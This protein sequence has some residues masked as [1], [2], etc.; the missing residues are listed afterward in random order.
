MSA[1]HARKGY[2]EFD[3]GQERDERGRFSG[4]GSVEPGDPRKLKPA[5]EAGYLYH[6]TN[7]LNFAD[8]R[9]DGELRV[10]GPSYGTD[11]DE[12]PDGGTEDRSYWNAKPSVVES[13]Y[14]EEG[15]PVL[16]RARESAVAFQRERYTSDSYTRDVVPAS[17]LEYLGSDGSWHA[18]KVSKGYPEFDPD[19]PRD[20]GGRF[21][22]ASG[23][24]RDA[25]ITEEAM[26]RRFP[27]ARIVAEQQG[28]GRLNVRITNSEVELN[29]VV[30][31][32]DNAYLG[33]IGVYGESEEY[34]NFAREGLGIVLDAARANNAPAIDLYAVQVGAYVWPKIGFELRSNL[35]A[36]LSNGDF[37]RRLERA[38]SVLPDT[39]WQAVRDVMDVR[40]VTLPH[41]L[42]NLGYELSH[43]DYA[44]ISGFP[45]VGKPM[46]GKALLHRMSGNYTL[47][48]AKF[49][50]LE[51]Y[52]QV[53]KG[54]PEFD[55][56]QPRNEDGTWGSTGRMGSW[57]TKE[58]VEARF[59]GAAVDYEP[60]PHQKGSFTVT[61]RNQDEAH[62]LHLRVSYYPGSGSGEGQ[63][64][65]GLITTADTRVG[66]ETA[67][68]A[69]AF[70]L[71]MAEESGARSIFLSAGL[72]SGGYVWP[73]IGF[74]SY[75]AWDSQEDYVKRLD[76]AKAAGLS[77][78]LY[79]K[80]M[81]VVNNTEPMREMPSA[82]AQ[83]DDPVPLDVFE[84]AV[85]FIRTAAGVKPTLGK[86]ILLAQGGSF[87]LPREKYSLL[88]DW[89]SRPFSK[90]MR[91]GYPEFDPNQP[92]EEDGQWGSGG[93]TRAAAGGK[94]TFDLR[95]ERTEQQTRRLQEMLPARFSVMVSRDSSTRERVID[96][97]SPSETFVG[98]HRPWE[99]NYAA[100]AGFRISRNG[101]MN[102]D[103]F[104]SQDTP[105]GRAAASAI[106]RAMYLIAMDSD[107]QQIKIS[108]GLTMGGYVWPRVGFEYTSSKEATDAARSARS[109]LLDLM[110]SDAITM[111]RYRT[112]KAMLVEAQ[113]TGDKTVG[114]KIAHLNDP[115]PPAL[116]GTRVVRGRLTLGKFILAGGGGSFALPRSKFR[117]LKVLGGGLTKGYPEYD[118]DQP[119]NEDGR[120]S[121][122]ETRAAVAR[123]VA[124]SGSDKLDHRKVTINDLRSALTERTWAHGVNVTVRG[125][126][127]HAYQVRIEASGATYGIFNVSN[128]GK[129]LD[130]GYLAVP[131]DASGRRVASVIMRML[132]DFA[133]ASGMEQITTSAGLEMGGYTWPRLGFNLVMDSTADALA[134][135]VRQRARK[136]FD[137]ALITQAEFSDIDHTLTYEWAD[138]GPTTI[139]KLDRPMNLDNAQLFSV[140]NTGL[141][142]RQTL[143]K[144][145]LAGTRGNYTLP[146]AKF[147]VLGFSKVAKGYPEF[148]PNQPRDEGGRFAG[149][150]NLN[151]STASHDD[152]VKEVHSRIGSDVI[153]RHTGRGGVE[154]KG[155]G[156]R[157][158]SAPG[159]KMLNLSYSKT[160]GEVHVGIIKAPDTSQGSRWAVA[161]MKMIRDLALSNNA[162]AIKIEAALGMGGYL[163]PRIGFELESLQAE[164][165]LKAAVQTRVHNLFQDY[166]SEAQVQEVYDIL[167]AGGRDMGT[168]LAWLDHPVSDGLQRFVH[169]T[170]PQMRGHLTLGKVL[171]AG[172]K[173]RYQLRSGSFNALN[174]VIPGM[175]KRMRKGYPEYNQSQ[176]R[177]EDGR[178]SAG[179]ALDLSDGD[180]LSRSIQRR[181]SGV[182]VAIGPYTAGFDVAVGDD[183]NVATFFVSR[184]KGPLTFEQIKTVDTP[185]GRN[186]ARMALQ[187]V[188]DTA[189][190]SGAPLIRLRAAGAGGYV[191]PAVGFELSTPAELF[192]QSNNLAERVDTA[193]KYLSWSAGWML[194]RL[195][196]RGG[197]NLPRKL[198]AL[199]TPLTHEQMADISG[200]NPY[201]KQVSR[202]TLGK[203]L[204]VGRLRVACFKL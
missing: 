56:S 138:T 38:R 171:L 7:A 199:N 70:V 36:W 37:V 41:R 126:Y 203:A 25:G 58:G 73:R 191:W 21:A 176:S 95:G 20:E 153:V 167:G 102:A 8:I 177:G 166:M 32:N 106:M 184:L 149:A 50:L 101:V 18:L 181:F 49:H 79:D 90:R 178:W 15:K 180:A 155:D 146:R 131:N 169:E 80:G 43:T 42:A 61:V 133:T 156:G 163:W 66:R 204:L 24:Y 161:V 104:E 39:A 57:K 16:L 82:V 195:V 74:D 89:L 122:G 120:W 114:T 60:N 31:D 127:P 152:F 168:K 147:N 65:L 134:E 96:I 77:Q 45:A 2:P 170:F 193:K 192:V 108:A 148:N 55:P 5:A 135:T 123:T 182:G 140:S 137:K 100:M 52:A 1:R 198:A 83:L 53:R 151:L 69:L 40:D 125:S 158:G 98:P 34:K 62:D 14:P 144:V 76:E 51:R 78:A 154:I 22:G 164:A 72:E 86:L 30:R 185:E 29:F 46:L 175:R 179:A 119:R 200:N 202:A 141:R 174:A 99:R 33:G 107:V 63:V 59:P 97:Y 84:T 23:M 91:K 27:G 87:S 172:T 93:E 85:G 13:F 3:P 128:D 28:P 54:Y 103:L 6:G 130:A 162:D 92:R 190:A 110:M 64:N 88:R 12:W 139:A 121:G 71:D 194:D 129:T 186:F 173:A 157:D 35:D 75:S 160:L 183:N 145:L 109:D 132:R 201:I 4:G 143:G 48:K 142:G 112:I 118:R 187:L 196:R 67:R 68:R 159:E 17:K 11:Q 105:E 9:N 197:A 188:L 124:R 81:A 117:N 94:G 19:Q 44:Q 113:R 111:E 189:K 26:R 150:H 47:P 165:S 116:F 136:L 115:I 10:H